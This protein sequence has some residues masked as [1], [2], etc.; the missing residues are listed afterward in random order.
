ML[1]L[2]RKTNE[3]IVID[4]RITITVVQV[5]GDTVRL[6]FDAPQEV[7]IHREEIQRRL[8]Q[9]GAV[10]GRPVAL[11]GTA[12]LGGRSAPSSAA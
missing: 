2:S 12:S 11:G 9:G 6:A 5:K 1:V 4:G 3:R 10:D 8:E 7:V